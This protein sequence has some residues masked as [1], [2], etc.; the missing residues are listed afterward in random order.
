MLKNYIKTALRNISRNKGFTTI[1]ISGLAIGMACCILV[2]LY[3]NDEFSFDRYPQ[4]SDQIYRLVMGVTSQERG[5]IQTARTPPPWAPAL[6][7]DYPEVEDYVRFK[8]PL[9]SWLISYEEKDKR[10]HE[11]GF[12]FADPSVFEFF[13]FALIKGYPKTALSEPNTVVLTES[14]AKKYFGDEDPINKILRADNTYD[15]NVVGIIK[16]VPKHSHITFDILASFKTLSTFAI[17]GGIEYETFRFMGLAPDNYTYLRLK[18]GT[19]SDQF[20]YKFPQFFEKYISTQMEQ[21]GLKIKPQLQPLKNIHLHSNI[22]AELQANS[23]INY[24]YIFSAIALFVLIIACI[25]FMN[26]ST[27]LSSKRASEVGLRKVVGAYRSQ[28]IIQFLVETIFLTFIALFLA[29]ILVQ[30]LLPLFNYFSGKE[31][32]LAFN[33]PWNILGIIGIVVFVGILSG[34]YPAFMLSSFQPATVLKGGVK[35]GSLNAVLR[36]VLVLIQFSISIIFI[37]G[38]GIVYSQLKFIQNRELGFNKEQV[39]VLPFGDPRAR[40]IYLSY[41]NLITQNPNVVAASGVSSLPGGLINNAAIR[42]EGMAPD[43]TVLVEFLFGDHDFLDV[44]GIELAAGRNFSLDF[45]TDTLAAFILNET[46]INQFGWQDSPLE[47][48]IQLGGW[49]GRVIGVVKDFHV[50]SLY[51]RIEPLMIHIAPNPDAYHY[52]A[53]KIKAENFQETLNFLEVKWKQVYPHDPFVYSFLDED[54]DSQYRTEQ[55]RGNIFISFSILAIFIA[56]LGLFGLAAFTAEQR[57]KEI[58]IRKVLGASES[59]IVFRL[60]K[61]FTIW[62]LLA[63]FIAWPVAFLAMDKWLQNFAYRTGIPM[64][65]FFV[66]AVI[67]LLIAL[68]TVSYQAIKA[69]SSNPVEAL[70]YE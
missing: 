9:V 70:R 32:S 61:E 28:L 47:K 53:V 18:K 25:N 41:E 29:F 33:N 2:L 5:E 14:A 57:T 4:Q 44:M 16:D 8:T 67:A 64:W 49:Q 40:Q 68:I 62:V 45:P 21:L 19:S 63:N 50:K 38:T 52:F 11:K 23:D 54:F 3:T 46:A 36:K 24:I 31:L 26:L 51:Q 37:I 66:A 55:L 65:I 35:A 69:A 48:R 6:A 42:T 20:L 56:C 39:V 13:N 60:S 7:N 43:Q 12:Y 1:N 34:S 22:E 27:A 17:Y 15:F 59:G 58:G 30:L 10:F